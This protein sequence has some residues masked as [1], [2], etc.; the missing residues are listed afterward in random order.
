MSV[1]GGSLIGPISNMVPCEGIFLKLVW[2]YSCLNI[3][4]A[5]GYLVKFIIILA[6]GKGIKP[7]NLGFQELT[8]IS[9]QILCSVLLMFGW[10]TISMWAFLNTI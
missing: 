9:G 8:M 4:F 5:L 1:I 10:T 6:K 7:K 3:L 2:R